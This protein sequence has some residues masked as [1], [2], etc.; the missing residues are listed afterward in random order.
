MAA[1]DWLN[2][3]NCFQQ[4]REGG[5]A[6]TWG[7]CTGNILIMVTSFVSLVATLMLLSWHLGTQGWLKLE[8]Y[9]KTKTWVFLL[10]SLN[11]FTV[12]LRYTF[13]L[14]DSVIY[15]PMLVLA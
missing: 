8:T 7:Y 3:A 1:A 15:L 4:R 13:L 10:L 6:Y 14:Y 9:K 11:L 5:F 2:S 12:V